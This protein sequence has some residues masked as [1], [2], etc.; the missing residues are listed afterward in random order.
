MPRSI[1]SS[2]SRT[3]S[4]SS[5]SRE[6]FVDNFR[7]FDINE[8]DSEYS[9]PD[10]IPNRRISNVSELSIA[11]HQSFSF[12]GRGNSTEG[13]YSLPPPSTQT[14]NRPNSPTVARRTSRSSEL[15]Q[16]YEENLQ[17]G[18]STVSVLASLRG[19]SSTSVNSLMSVNSFAVDEEYSQPDGDCI[20]LAQPLDTQARSASE[21][22]FEDDQ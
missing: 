13:D 3:S 7:G 22:K 20:K 6:S 12:A 1:I 15:G 5:G 2:C 8:D 14:S 17:R 21:N 16:P 4:H 18:K 11:S 19:I 9:D 10:V